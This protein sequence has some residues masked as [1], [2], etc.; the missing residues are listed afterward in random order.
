[1]RQA[2]ERQWFFA[3]VQHLPRGHSRRSSTSWPAADRRHAARSPPARSSLH[4]AAGAPAVPAR[5]LLRVALDVQTSLALFGRI[6]EYLDLEPAHR[7]RARTR[8][9]ST[10]PTHR[11]GRVRRRLVPLPRAPSRRDGARGAEPPASGRSQDVSFA[12]EPG[13]FAAI[14]GPSGAGKTTMSY[15]IPRFYDV[16]GG[17]VLL[18]GHDVRDLTR[19]R[20]PT[21]SAWSPRR[22]TC[23]TRRSP[24]TCATPSRTPP[25]AELEAAARAA[26]IHDRIDGLRRGLRHRRRAS[27]ATGSPAARSSASPSP[28]CCSRTR[29]C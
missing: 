1:M 26:N 5:D 6:F 12:I 11:P 18:D 16:D 9:R 4:H 22:P 7:R 8:A 21:R 28:G 23:S 25:T 20:S 2:D 17:R 14:V 19:P 24:R 3:V 27:A 29:G 10:A 13:Q 15:L